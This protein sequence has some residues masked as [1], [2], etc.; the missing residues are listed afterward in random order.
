MLPL[1]FG[2][3]W[4]WVFSVAVWALLTTLI[5]DEKGGFAFIALCGT[6]VALAFAGD[7]NILRVA[8]AHPIQAV[9]FFLGYLFMGAL[10]SLFKWWRLLKAAK[11]R[12]NQERAKFFHRQDNK[13]AGQPASTG[14]LLAY[15]YKETKFDRLI[16]KVSEHKSQIISWMCYWPMSL[17]WY[18]LSDWIVNLFNKI[19]TAL[20]GVFIGMRNRVFSDVISDIGDDTKLD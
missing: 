19:F 11:E 1:V 7:I 10:W 2:S 12:F 3:F 15:F 20:K 18:F 9:L 13:I 4:F 16:P 17:V 6:F 8:Q 5:E 14:E